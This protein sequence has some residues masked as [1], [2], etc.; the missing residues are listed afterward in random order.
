VLVNSSS[1]EDE[2]KGE[3]ITYD[4]WEPAVPLSPRAEGAAPEST[5]EMGAEP[6]IAGSSIGRR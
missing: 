2:S 3:R 6:P 4:R 1:N 5:L